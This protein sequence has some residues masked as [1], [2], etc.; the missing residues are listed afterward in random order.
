M[1]SLMPIAN[2]PS[3]KMPACHSV[4][5]ALQLFLDFNLNPLFR[6]RFQPDIQGG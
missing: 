3:T 6:H 1:S 2:L 4:R 5:T